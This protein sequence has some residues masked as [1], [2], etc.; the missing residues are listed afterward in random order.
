MRETRFVWLMICLLVL[1]GMLSQS[2]AYTGENGTSPA[3]T[4][5]PRQD[6]WWMERHN[7]F[8]ERVRQGNV[9]I[10]FIGDSITHGWEDEGREI[11]DAV[12]APR[13]AVNLGIGGDQTCHVLWRLQ[14]GNLEGIHPKVAV[15]MI[16]TNNGPTDQT[17][18]EIADGVKAIVNLIREKTP[19]TRILL[20][21]IFPRNDQPEPVQQK[22]RE[23]TA[24]FATLDADPMVEFVDIN[25]TFLDESGKIP[26]DIMPDLLH[27]NRKGYALWA[28]A[29]EPWLGKALGEADGWTPLFNGRDLTGLEEVGGGP[30]SWRVEH[31]M[32]VTVGGGG[33]WIST[34]REFGDFELS[35]E[36]KSPPGGNSGVFIRAPREGNP[37]FEGSE[38]QILDDYSDRYKELKPYQYCGSVYATI[39]PAK[40]ATKP[41]GEWQ[42][43]VIRV[44]GQ[45]IQVTLNGEQIV[46][47]DLS[48]HLD[49]VKDHP[50]LQR[51]KGYI[52]LQ[53]HDTPMYFRNI[54][55]REL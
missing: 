25:W 8:N 51:L 19:N 2:P 32:L 27:P 43:M 38:I 10:V 31:G 15:I 52:G 35:V 48:E 54:L 50:G 24:L 42:K 12:Y 29:L 6:A 44:Q 36:F 21:A 1:G 45:K 18:E 17:A 55:V 49:K 34:T 23:A 30:S 16:G 22:L 28:E 41:A 47:G 14:N 5:M 37:A 11:W 3:V 9:D 20:L 39:A 46:N 13:N 40:R 33:N 7:S 4:P 53:N 26:K